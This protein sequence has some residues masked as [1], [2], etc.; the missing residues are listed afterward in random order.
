MHQI[1]PPHKRPNEELLD[2]MIFVV[3]C[4][5]EFI[6]SITSL[7]RASSSRCEPC[8]TF[9]ELNLLP[10]FLFTYSMEQSLRS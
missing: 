1:S 7:R 6:S 4:I 10:D 8:D 3:Q 9:W 5:S 2:S